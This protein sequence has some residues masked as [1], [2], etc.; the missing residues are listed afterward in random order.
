VSRKEP[1]RLAIEEEI[2]SIKQQLRLEVDGIVRRQA[3]LILSAVSDAERRMIPL[4][5]YLDAAEARGRETPATSDTAMSRLKRCLAAAG[6]GVHR[7]ELD[8]FV[9]ATGL[10]KASARK[11]RHDAE[12]EG[13]ASCTGPMWMLTA[14]GRARLSGGT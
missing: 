8:K 1:T 13:T 10:T 3:D 9:M 12:A 5:A 2:A 11:A 14:A 6:S 4:R 7:D